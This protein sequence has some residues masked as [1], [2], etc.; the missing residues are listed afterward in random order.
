MKSLKITWAG[1]L[2]AAMV[3]ASFGCKKT[4]STPAGGTTGAPVAGDDSVWIKVNG[5]DILRSEIE[6]DIADIK[7]KMGGQMP[8]EQMAMMEPTIKRETMKRAVQRALLD[9]MVAKDGIIADA[10]KVDE[11]MAKI[12]ERFPDPNMLEQK[13]AEFNMTEDSLKQEIA[14]NL[15]YQQLFE[16]NAPV[17]D[18]SDEEI[19]QVYDRAKDRLKEPEQVKVT[20][21][22]LMV[23]S[24]ASEETKKQK[25]GLAETIR[26][27]ILAGEDMAALA[28]KYSD[29]PNKADKG[30]ETFPKGQMPEAF[31]TAVFALKPGELSRV[32]ETPV[33]YHIVRMQELIPETSTP[34]EEVR[35]KII[36]YLKEDQQKKAFDNYIEGLTKNADVQYLEPLPEETPH[37]MGG[38]MMMGAEPEEGSTP[39]PVTPEEMQPETAPAPPAEAPAPA[40]AP[41]PAPPSPAPAAPGP[42]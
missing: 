37:G 13:L 17:P 8:P 31:D 5:Q 34:L 1:L 6:N 23:P 22:V 25:K 36:A 14:K 16:K 32:I 35:E 20:H 9:Q 41:A 7:K 33:G 15:A 38:P 3:L 21:I 28:E 19:Q 24:S 26:K 27:K 29:S 12:K 39:E 10:A 30:I 2:L 40:A 4:E 42:E 11:E 18:P